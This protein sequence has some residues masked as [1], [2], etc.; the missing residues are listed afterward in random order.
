MKHER[1]NWKRYSSVRTVVRTW[2]L[3]S[4]VEAILMFIRVVKFAGRKP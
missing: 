2:M 4:P 1:P 3:K